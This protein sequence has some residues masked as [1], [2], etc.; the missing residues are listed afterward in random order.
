[1]HLTRYDRFQVLEY[2]SR[3]AIAPR[4]RAHTQSAWDAVLCVY[5]ISL[6]GAMGGFFR[7]RWRLV[8]SRCRV[9]I[10]RCVSKVIRSAYLEHV[11]MSWS[12]GRHWL[13][14]RSVVRRSAGRTRSD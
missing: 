13:M 7:S 6:G 9:M 2:I 11:D 14:R 3:S 8:S 4:V 12:A 10:L 5:L 1:M